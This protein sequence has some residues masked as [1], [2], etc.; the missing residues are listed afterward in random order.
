MSRCENHASTFDRAGFYL[1]FLGQDKPVDYEYFRQL[2]SRYAYVP[3]CARF[4]L[5]E[6]NKDDKRPLV[7]LAMVHLFHIL[8]PAPPACFLES[9]TGH[10]NGRYSIIA[11][12]S[13]DLIKTIPSDPQGSQVLQNFINSSRVMQL[14]LPFFSGG[15]IGFWS[16]ESGLMYHHLPASKDVLSEQVFFM[17]GEILVYDRQLQTL[18]VIFWLDSKRA[19]LSEFKKA[20][21]RRDELFHLAAR[22]CIE[23]AAPAF[24]RWDDSLPAEFLP[25]LG[26][27]EFCTM[28]ES[29]QKH[30]QQG[31]V[32]QVVLSRRWRK[33]SPASPW[34]VYLQL[35]HINPSPYMFYLLLPDQVLLGASPEMQVK[36]EKGRVKSRPIAGTRKKTGNPKIDEDICQELLQDEKERAEHLMLVDLSRNDIGRVS[37]PGTV[38]VSEFMQLEAYSHVVHIVST[39]EGELAAGIDALEAFASCFPAGTLSGAPKRKAMEII[40]RLEKDSRGPYGGAVG[41]IDFNGTLDSC[42]TIRSILHKNGSYYLQSGAGIVADS[43]P[44]R[45]DEE[46]YHKARALMVAIKEAERACATDD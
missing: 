31:D 14:D 34:Q 42:I 24:L 29:A 5:E 37:R 13:L 35:R 10:D 39:V 25:N 3:L 28:V 23:E 11:G 4:S 30:I 45:E 22:C 44:E 27:E 21:R 43:V 16:Y 9:L 40:N 2:A 32:F 18:T 15:L 36:V 46:T 26:R 19:S 17:P 1:P 41:F 12:K 6:L 38:E 7:P 20:C 8:K 33:K